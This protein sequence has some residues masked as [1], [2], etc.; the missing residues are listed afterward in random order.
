M[1]DPN[2]PHRIPAEAGRDGGPAFPQIQRPLYDPHEPH[3]GVSLRDYFAASYEPP[4]WVIRNYLG[5]I[6][7]ADLTESLSI[8]DMLASVAVIKYRHADAMLEARE[9]SNA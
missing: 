9:V 4:E 1:A 2:E 3:P 8:V 6:L 7:D 5:M